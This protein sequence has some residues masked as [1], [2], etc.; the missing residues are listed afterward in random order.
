M[1]FVDEVGSSGKAEDGHCDCGGSYK[2]STRPS[3]NRGGHCWAQW[4]F[5]EH[6]PVI[7]CFV[8]AAGFCASAFPLL[9]ASVLFLYPPSMGSSEQSQS[10]SMWHRGWAWSSL[11]VRKR[12][13]IL[14]AK[15]T[16]INSCSS[17]SELCEQVQ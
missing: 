12:L 8:L 15:H 17:S 2:P 10:L 11:G 6:E 7:L 13:L 3:G 4:S 9:K 14:G 16:V 5:H 1:L